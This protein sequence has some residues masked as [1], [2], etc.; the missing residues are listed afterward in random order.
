M[1]NDE[2]LKRW[3]L[4][5]GEP[6]ETMD[7]RLDADEARMDRALSAL[8]DAERKGGLGGSSPNVNRWLG[9]IRTYFPTSVV[10][11]MQRDALERLNLSQM[12]TEPEL[13][14][15]IEADVHLV[16]TLL[17]LRHVIPAR[18]RETARMVVRKVVDELEKKLRYPM[19]AAVQGSLNRASRSRRPRHREIDWDRTIR[20]NLA[21]YLPEKRTIIAERLIGYGRKCS[22]LRDVVLCVDQSG[23]M[24][25]SV[26]YSGIFAA[27]LASLRAVTTKLVVFDT[28]IVDLTDKLSDPVEVLFGTQLGGGTDINRALGYCTQ[29][30]TRPSQTIMVLITDLYEG[31]DA[32]AMLKR[33]AALVASGVQVICLLALSDEG[34]PFYDARMAARISALGIPAFSCTPDLFPDLMAAAI[35]KQDIGQWASRHDI[36]AVRGEVSR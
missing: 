17:S 13:L 20:A 24:A 21:N 27:V 9:D 19:T 14:E 16:A 28:S 6:A 3:R 26:V 15:T 25:P 5:L 12:L 7:V 35:Q 2:R 29:L 33:A 1:N 32:D 10:Q 8:Y 34:A 22:A 23:S 30:I 36:A 11:I 4:I 18:T 31:G